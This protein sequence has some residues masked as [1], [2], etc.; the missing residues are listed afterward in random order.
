ML[1][2]IKGRVSRILK[3][4]FRNPDGDEDEEKVE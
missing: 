4:H 1:F 3:Y 2:V